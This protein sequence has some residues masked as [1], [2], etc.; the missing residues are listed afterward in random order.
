M[1][2]VDMLKSQLGG[3]ILGK[4]GSVIGESEDKTKTA[5]TAAVPGLLAM[6]AQLASSGSGIEKVINAL[7][8]VETG[9]TGD[10]GDILSGE[11]SGQVIEKGGSLLNILLGSSALPVVLNLLSKFAGIAA[12]PAKNLLSLLAPLIL[13][14]IA[15]QLSG[16]SLNASTLSSF[17]AEQ[18]A[19]YQCRALLRASRWRAFPVFR[20]RAQLP[21][22][23]PRHPRK[24]PASPTGCF[25]WLAL[26][27]WLAW[28]G[29]SLATLNPQ[30]RNSRP[31]QR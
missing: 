11:K 7:R 8:Q 2:I 6:L 27:C 23:F 3:E 12:G 14:T 15:K 13:S 28:H 1:N 17:F 9:P 16:K 25:P 18:A 24:V 22:P 21:R 4:L 10:I 31:D 30:S 20:P 26:P 19:A 5:V 29:T